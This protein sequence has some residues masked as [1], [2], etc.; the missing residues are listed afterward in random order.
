MSSQKNY[1]VTRTSSQ[2]L[3]ETLIKLIIILMVMIVIQLQGCEVVE[4][5]SHGSSF[6]EQSESSKKQQRS[7]NRK[8]A[9]RKRHKVNV[10]QLSRTGAVVIKFWKLSSN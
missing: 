9:R 6:L 1:R 10:D 3:K 2:I 7:S 8:R 5:N 4:K